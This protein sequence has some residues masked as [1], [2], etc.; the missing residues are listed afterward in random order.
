MF[1]GVA[2][3]QTWIHPS[4]DGPCKSWRYWKYI[5]EPAFGP[6]PAVHTIVFII[7]TFRTDDA[8]FSADGEWFDPREAY[9]LLVSA[10]VEKKK[11]RIGPLAM[12]VFSSHFP[13]GLSFKYNLSVQGQVTAVFKQATTMTTSGA[14]LWM[15]DWLFWEL[16][17]LSE[18]ELWWHGS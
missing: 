5:E 14:A 7:E 15:P 9:N 10:D 16:L 17:L 4:S 2:Q 13:T 8:C 12:F 18:W 11:K 3:I 6:G 1:F